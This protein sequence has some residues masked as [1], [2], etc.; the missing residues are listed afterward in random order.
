[1]LGK[2]QKGVP[3]YCFRQ[4][5]APFFKKKESKQ[6]LSQRYPY[7]SVVMVAMIYL[8]YNIHQSCSNL[9]KITIYGALLYQNIL[10]NVVKIINLIKIASTWSN[11]RSILL[12]QL[13]FTDAIIIAATS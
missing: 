1:M 9:I 8:C 2:N 12:L 10:T 11:Y 6:Y 5:N 13:S 4:K 7:S 3:Y